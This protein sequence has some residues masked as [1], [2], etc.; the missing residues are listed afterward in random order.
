MAF[1]QGSRSSSASSLDLP[2]NS[3]DI[4]LLELIDTFDDELVNSSN[5]IE[6]VVAKQQR[7]QPQRLGSVNGIF[8][9]MYSGKTTM[10]YREIDRLKILGNETILAVKPKLDDRYSSDH[11]VDH[12]RELKLKCMTFAKL[13]DI[14][15]YENGSLFESATVIGIDEAQFFTDLAEF[16]EV[17]LDLGKDVIFAALSGDVSLKNPWT[18]IDRVRPIC[19]T[20]HCLAALCMICRD[21]SAGQYSMLIEGG[22]LEEICIGSTDTYVSVCFNCWRE[23]NQDLEFGTNSDYYKNL[24]IANAIENELVKSNSDHDLEIEPIEE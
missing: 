17:C 18:C 13:G 8:G 2:K 11:I 3:S 16:C 1:L 5:S 22:E 9:P 24:M 6:A 20:Q 14:I 21:R 4:S 15:T 10:L 7:Q 12:S 19:T 23:K